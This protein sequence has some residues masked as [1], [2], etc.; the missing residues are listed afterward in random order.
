VQKISNPKIENCAKIMRQENKS[1]TVRHL[2]LKVFET[3]E[4]KNL[5]RCTTASAARHESI[6]T[7]SEQYGK[8]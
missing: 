3:S 2:E 1:F 8:S 6:Y 5:F 7:A 4:K